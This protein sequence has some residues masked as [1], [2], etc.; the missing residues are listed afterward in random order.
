MRLW[1]IH[2]YMKAILEHPTLRTLTEHCLLLHLWLVAA[3]VLSDKSRRSQCPAAPGAVGDVFM[4]PTLVALLLWGRMWFMSFLHFMWSQSLCECASACL[5]PHSASR[6][7]QYR[8]VP[9]RL[10]ETHPLVLV[11]P[12]KHTLCLLMHKLFQLEP[13]WFLTEI[14]PSLPA[15]AKCGKE[16]QVLS[17]ESAPHSCLRQVQV[18][19]SSGT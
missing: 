9:P 1:E 2:F 17:S 7:L 13:F 3:L 19:E 5:C 4:V 16:S 15:S 12:P 8:E 6:A 10:H 11:L 18:L 14:I